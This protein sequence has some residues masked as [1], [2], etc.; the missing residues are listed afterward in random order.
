[1]NLRVELW[2]GW[3]SRRNACYAGYH[4]TS[5]KRKRD[6]LDYFFK[7]ASENEIFSPLSFLQR[8]GKKKEL[9]F[10]TYYMLH[11]ML[12]TLTTEA[13]RSSQISWEEERTFLISG[14]IDRG[15]YM[16]VEFVSTKSGGQI[17]KE[18]LLKMWSGIK[19][20]TIPTIRGYFITNYDQP[21]LSHMTSVEGKMGAKK[22]RC[23]NYVEFLLIYLGTGKEQK[24]YV[25]AA[26][27]F[28][29][30]QVG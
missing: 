16:F 21:L 20:N 12:L 15:N 30:G 7:W 27:G 3:Y 18:R 10:L 2:L 4:L 25:R 1:M 5:S 24:R 22:F 8:N 26:K 9:P 17:F 13:L 11:C 6:K 14:K 23:I 28:A 29:K 19:A